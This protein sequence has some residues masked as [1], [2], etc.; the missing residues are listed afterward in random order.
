[1]LRIDLNMI[2]R[3]IELLWFGRPSSIIA[4]IL[5]ASV[6]IIITLLAQNTPTFFITYGTGQLIIL[7]IIVVPLTIT[8][9]F[10]LLSKAGAS[11]YS[12]TLHS[13]GYVFKSVGLHVLTGC[14]AVYIGYLFLLYPE[15]SSIMP[16]DNGILA[17]LILSAI[18]S[19]LLAGANTSVVF[20][21]SKTRKKRR[22]ITEFISECENLESSAT[23]A[24]EAD[25]DAIDNAASRLRTELSNEPMQDSSEVER[26][27]GEWHS[28]FQQYNTGGQ[29]K[30][31]G[32]GVNPTPDSD[33]S[34]VS[35]YEKYQLVRKQLSN[36]RTSAFSSVTNGQQS[37]H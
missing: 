11:T 3:Y 26:Q 33:G 28:K 23:S 36:M 31:V 13:P 17:G 21:Q 15:T 30:M 22:L 37:N 10:W 14:V 34:W 1:M 24:I 2:R 6:P 8:I 25:T 18:Y 12:P 32:A 20:S 5:V 4:Q 16:S 19:I 9:N 7:L 35:L 27:L 29:R